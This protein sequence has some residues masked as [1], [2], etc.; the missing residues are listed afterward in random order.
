MTTIAESIRMPLTVVGDYM[1]M[2]AEGALGA[3]SKDQV[4]TLRMLI[5]KTGEIAHAV[6]HLLPSQPLPE[7]DEYER[8]SLTEIIRRVC[9]RRIADAQLAVLN[10]VTRPSLADS[11]PHYAIIGNRDALTQAFDTLLSEAIQSS[12][13]SGVIYVSLH[14]SHKIFYVKV[15]YPGSSSFTREVDDILVLKKGSDPRK[16]SLAIAKR[17]IEEHS[18]QIWAQAEAD[19]VSAFYVVLPKTNVE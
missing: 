16:T 4:S 9:S 12:T 7:T 14:T 17:T 19:H 1:E 3:V 8:I 15:S 2:L 5:E 6:D 13:G 10:L 18:G 11:E